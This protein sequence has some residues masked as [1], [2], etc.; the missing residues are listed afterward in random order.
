MGR[1]SRAKRERARHPAK[2]AER[3]GRALPPHPDAYVRQVRRLGGRGL[4]EALIARHNLRWENTARHYGTLGEVALPIHST[5]FY[6]DVVLD[7][8]GVPLPDRPAS[9]YGSWS[10]QVQWGLDSLSVGSRFLL[11]GNALGAA[12][13]ARNQL[14]RWTAN[15]A[16]TF[17]IEREDDEDTDQFYT[18][19]WEGVGEGF[20]PAGAVWTTLSE[21][22]HG[23]PPAADNVAWESIGLSAQAPT[24]RSMAALRAAECGLRL[25]MR[26]LKGCVATIFDSSPQG[27]LRR[28]NM[29]RFAPEYHD[30]AIVAREV[31]PTVWPMTHSSIDSI[32]AVLREP[33]G[34]YREEVRRFHSPS[35][36]TGD[37]VLGF[38]ELGLHSYIERRWRSARGAIAAREAERVELGPRFD[39]GSLEA[40]EHAYI[41][42]WELAALIAS[43]S[44]EPYR[45]A[46]CSASSALR[47]G[48]WLWLE[49]DDRA[50]VLARTCLES[51]AQARVHRTKPV[52]SERMR[53][54]SGTVPPARWLDAA[55][56]RRLAALNRSLGEFAHADPGRMRWRGAHQALA[57]LHG[58]EENSP[59]K[60]IQTARG[61]TVN[62]CA[63]LLLAECLECLEDIA[64][65]LGAAIDDLLGEDA[66]S[67][68]DAWLNHVWDERG[69]DLGPPD[70]TIPR[71][72]DG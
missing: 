17:A 41:L 49:D 56:W 45:T 10:E 65:S 25:S 54:T 55:G 19:V 42:I 1:K 13:I 34:Q 20:P 51:L 24:T 44:D 28:L 27:S 11:A 23:R 36:V 32:A 59:S 40:R 70:M 43:W 33:A 2:G 22:L 58:R 26:Q 71:F 8:V 39:P 9:L 53:E 66:T 60:P 14:D 3:R 61:D 47:A 5:V 15:R 52:R 68:T 57:A 18:R 6:L 4:K 12:A 30:L 35:D 67:D 50:M 21:T 38:P 48:F 62:R 29:A 64:P 46:L 72:Q 16:F 31:G 37:A 63:L 69:I 7:S